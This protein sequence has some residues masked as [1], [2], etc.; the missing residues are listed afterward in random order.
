MEPTSLDNTWWEIC[1][2]QALISKTT[3]QRRSLQPEPRFS[4]H[5][6]QRVAKWFMDGMLYAD[7][8]KLKS[9]MISI[10]ICHRM[11]DIPT[12]STKRLQS[13]GNRF[14]RFLRQKEWRASKSLQG[15]IASNTGQIRSKS[16]NVIH[17]FMETW[18][19]EQSLKSSCIMHISK[20]VDWRRLN[21]SHRCL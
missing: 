8:C 16:T 10:A 21:R 2:G 3:I 13:W 6:P 11:R 1:W 14:S 15:I 12:W 20:Y 17:Q 7:T 18:V 9:S 4:S 19:Q 5:W